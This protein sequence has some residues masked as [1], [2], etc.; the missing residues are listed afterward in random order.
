[1][2]SW[3]HELPIAVSAAVIVAS[4]LVPALIGSALLQP[5]VGRLLR[6]QKD[7]NEFA[8]LL[9]NAFS[10]FYGVLLAL[11]SIAVFDNYSKAQD[12][13]GHEASGIVGLYRLVN[14]YPEPLRTSLTDLLRR[15]V[16]EETGAGWEEQR[17][18]RVPWSG[19]LLVDE[20]SRQLLS[21]KPDRNSGEAILHG[22][23][24]RT[25]RE[26]IDRRSIRMQA[27]ATTIPP[28]VWYVVVTGAI[29][30]VLILWL[31]DLKRTTHFILAGVL[32]M[33]IGLTIF[34]VAVLDQ[35]FR[36]AHGL[37]PDDLINA[38]QQMSGSYIP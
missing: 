24:L 36:G 18:G 22:E 35:P 9:L 10:L 27:A 37:D 33:F 31:F 1:V 23:G 29:L 8:G 7:P 17:H 11:L 14:A 19:T 21:Y 15:Y 38:R 2:V 6:S 32:M 3:L 4:F 28:V 5:M 13:I 25:Y 30:N 16:E 34:M 12:A 20:L 26:F